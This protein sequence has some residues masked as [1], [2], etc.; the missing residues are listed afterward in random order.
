VLSCIK[1]FGGLLLSEYL[2]A[3]EIERCKKGRLTKLR[4]T[5]LLGDGKGDA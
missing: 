2:W 5:V 4:S 1:D 3:V